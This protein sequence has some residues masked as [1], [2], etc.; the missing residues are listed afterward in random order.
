M[1]MW[2]LTT[3]RT[4][5]VTAVART[6]KCLTAVSTRDSKAGRLNG[7]AKTLQ[8]WTLQVV[9]LVLV[10]KLNKFKWRA[11]SHYSFKI[12]E[13]ELARYQW[14]TLNEIFNIGNNEKPNA[15]QKLGKLIFLDVHVSLR[16][17][18][19]RRITICNLHLTNEVSVCNW[20]PL[21]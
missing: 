2:E 4:S 20:V 21:D 17:L 19:T 6:I 7:G 18:F 1:S 9:L 10:L 3:V 12:Y 8:F 15:V 13:H 14:S 16:L 11:A 5:K